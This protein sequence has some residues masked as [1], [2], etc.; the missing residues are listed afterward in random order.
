[1]YRRE[2]N[3][4]SRAEAAG[5]VVAMASALATCLGFGTLVWLFRNGAFDLPHEP[6]RAYWWADFV[7][8]ATLAAFVAILG[9]LALFTVGEIKRQKRMRARSELP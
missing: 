8:Y 7:F 5:S 2:M 1:M 4:R 6:T 9:G 3:G